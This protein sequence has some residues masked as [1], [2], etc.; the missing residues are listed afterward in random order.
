MLIIYRRHLKSCPHRLDGRK[1]RRCHCPI[2][3]EGLLG[4]EPVRSALNTLLGASGQVRD[5]ERAQTLIRDWEA[6]GER[7]AASAPV[8]IHDAWEQYLADASARRLS[9]STL[10]EYRYV[11][12]NMENYATEKDFRYLKEFTLEALRKYRATWPNEN[13]SA[14]KKLELLRSFFRFACDSAWLPDNPA[15]KL[16][17]PKIVERPTLPFE[18][19][20]LVRIL[21]ALSK[22]GDPK[23]LNVRRVR[24]LVLLMR[25]SGLRISDA[26]TLPCARVLKGKLFLYTSKAGTPV[27]CPLP[28]VVIQALDAIHRAG[29]PYF[30]WTG[31]SKAKTVITHWWSCLKDV[32][33][34]AEIQN[35]HPHRFRDTFAVDLLLRGVPLERVSILLG[36]RSI[37]VTERHYAPWIRA[38]QEQLEADVRRAWDEHP[39]LVAETNHT[40]NT[41]EKTE[42]V[43]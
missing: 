22:Y 14:L 26:A 16:R 35:G 42:R 15:K 41:R 29:E 34:L 23:H 31:K 36:H 40:Y 18:P 43:N 28:P 27:S 20:E 2:H 8:T 5:W 30:F 25:F 38:R 9:E 19:E 4:D 1:Y 12:R 13:L 17:N 32:F 10:R 6:A 7:R 37:K 39:E 3:V 11:A 33:E 24:A 21:A